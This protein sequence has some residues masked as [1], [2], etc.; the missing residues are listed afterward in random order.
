MTLPKPTLPPQFSSQLED[1]VLEVFRNIRQLR[2]REHESGSFP[3]RPCVKDLVPLCLHIE[4]SV[5]K[6]NPEVRIRDHNSPTAN[7]YCSRRRECYI[8][9]NRLIEKL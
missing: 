6:G 9:W 1:S 7:I 4:G 2:L 5:E 8:S 3:N